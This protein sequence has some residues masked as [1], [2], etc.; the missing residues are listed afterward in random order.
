MVTCSQGVPS[1][2]TLVSCHTPFNT[3]A[4]INFLKDFTRIE[5]L[6]FKFLGAL[7]HAI[8]WA[9]V[10]EASLLSR[11]RH[12]EVDGFYLYREPDHV[13]MMPA[14][15]SL[16]GSLT[17]FAY[18][19]GDFR[20]A[21]ALSSEQPAIETAV[22]A[23]HDTL[24]RLVLP[25]E[26]A[27]V[28]LISS[29]P[30]PH[31][32]EFYLNGARWTDPNASPLTLFV[33][34]SRLRVLVLDLID[35]P[36]CETA[37]PVWPHHISMSKS[38]PWPELER[39][40][41]SNPTPSDQVYAHLP[42]TLRSLSLRPYPHHCVALWK[43]RKFTYTL[44]HDDPRLHS[45]LPSAETVQRILDSCSSITGLRELSLEYRADGTEQEMFRTAIDKF[46][47][48]RTLE[49]HRYRDTSR[50]EG[51]PDFVSTYPA[52]YPDS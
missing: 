47:H 2:N 11:L 42:Q 26:S 50:H 13:G 6:A 14:R 24:E 27:P 44:R 35:D 3:T 23:L 15:R 29:L 18:R 16:R 40:S 28:Q 4:F 49:V 12:L 38:F 20:S 9:L 21:L 39:I 8:P 43:K 30:W 31:L 51:T 34:M 45:P 33:G 19:K 52:A 5:C 32:R 25:T 17:S 37:P 41:I 1:N 7:G 46:P 36:N 10:H 22:Q 48:L